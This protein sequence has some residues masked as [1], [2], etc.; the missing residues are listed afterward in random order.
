MRNDI[1]VQTDLGGSEVDEHVKQIKQLRVM[2]EELQMKFKELLDK[3]KE[4]GFGD[5][6]EKIAQDMGIEAMFAYSTRPVFQRLYED[7][8]RRIRKL[9]KIRESIRLEREEASEEK[10][11]G[12]VFRRLILE[13]DGCVPVIQAVEESPL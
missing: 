12:K 5:E 3:C 10:P 9:E 8:L 2:L 7:A 13:E 4:R 11:D 1:A 6:L